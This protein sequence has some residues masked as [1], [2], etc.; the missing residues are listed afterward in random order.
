MSRTVVVALALLVVSCGEAAGPEQQILTNFFR[1]ARVRDNVTLGN[2]SAVS[3]DPRTE[4]SVEDYTIASVSEEQR[5]TLPIR[6]LTAAVEKAKADDEELAARKK[7]YQDA[8]FP[9]LQRIVKA[10]Q[11]KETVAGADVE[12][13][14]AW[15]RWRE[16][17]NQSSRRLSDAR[18]KL[19]TEQEQAV[20]SL[21]APNGADVDVSKMDVELA[22][23]AV[24]VNAQ[25]KTPEGATV[26]K[27]LV[28]TL[29][30]AVGKQGDQTT[31]GRWLIVGIQQQGGA[32]PTT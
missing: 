27:T 17:Q 13:Q 26:P 28:F 9:A 2:L 25:V 32:T 6:E 4:G 1:A 21:T 23:K 19:R 22:M 24:T 30:R 14:S 16:E 3:F 7:A 29:Q 31:E 15:T 18:T 5:R 20:A 12:I 10:E 11:A 8:N